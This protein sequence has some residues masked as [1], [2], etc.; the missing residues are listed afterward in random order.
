MSSDQKQLLKHVLEVYRITQL[1]QED[2]DAN[3]ALADMLQEIDPRLA[4]R[5]RALSSACQS[6]KDYIDLRQ[7]VS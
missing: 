2:I 6:L 1:E 4:V 3:M 7:E 5:L